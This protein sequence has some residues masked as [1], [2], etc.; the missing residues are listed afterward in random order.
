[1]NIVIN[2]LN[3]MIKALVLVGVIALSGCASRTPPVASLP[4]YTMDNFVANCPEAKTQMAFL[5]N[6]LVEYQEY[7]KSQPYTLED[8]R[9]YGKLKNALW[10]LR[11]TC[12]PNQL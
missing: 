2:K 6:K 9:Y 7:H 10:A 4:Y 5:D 3:K 12:R 8:Q 1:M 11:S